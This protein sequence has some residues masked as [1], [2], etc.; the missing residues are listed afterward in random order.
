MPVSAWIGGGIAVPGLT[1]VDHSEVTSK[2]STSMTPISVTR[3]Q[4]GWPP[5]VSKSTMASELCSVPMTLDFYP[6]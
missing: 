3:S 4:A 6:V 2:P 5:V 1:S